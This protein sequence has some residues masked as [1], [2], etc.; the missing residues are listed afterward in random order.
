MPVDHKGGKPEKNLKKQPPKPTKSKSESLSKT[1]GAAKPRPAPRPK[2][3]RLENKRL[4]DSNIA[5]M[6]D[7]QRAFEEF[8][9]DE[10]QLR[11][12]QCST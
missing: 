2:N 7:W 1:S 8:L 11:G 9:R 4:K 5:C 12:R 3:S 10:A 6:A